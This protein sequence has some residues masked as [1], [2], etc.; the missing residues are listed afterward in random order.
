M[1][2]ARSLH[3]E[4]AEAS[5]GDRALEEISRLRAETAELWVSLAEALA[6]DAE[7]EAEMEKLRAGFAVLQRMLFGRSPEKSRPE[8]SAGDGAGAAGGG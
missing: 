7:R 3:A 5:F 4:G 6:R 2:L 8:P 1:R